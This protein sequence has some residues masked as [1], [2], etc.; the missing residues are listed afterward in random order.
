MRHAWLLLPLAGCLDGFSPDVGPPLRATCVDTDSNTGHTVHFSDVEDVLAS[1]DGHCLD[2]HSP[3]S[4]AP[5]GVEVG[6]LDLSAYDYLRAGGVI[7][8]D[9]IVVPGQPCE[10]VL[11]QKVS[12]APP[13]GARMPLDGPPFLDDDEQ[14]VLA[15][16]IAEG[17][18]EE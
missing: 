5:V 15:D 3:A 10:S 14:R 2:C 13:F 17:A 11:V 4:P 6:G 7:S 1:R 16:W 18:H 9:R 12:A 8:G